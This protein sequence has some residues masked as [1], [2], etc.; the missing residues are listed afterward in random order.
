MQGF[1]SF[2]FLVFG[3]FCLVL[4]KAH[5]V[6]LFEIGTNATFLLTA[7]LELTCFSFSR[8][9]VLSDCFGF[10]CNQEIE[11]LEH[12]KSVLPIYLLLCCSYH[13]N[14]QQSLL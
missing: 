6:A 3:Q 8:E 12:C 10:Y 5:A 2:S 14:T 4:K 7:S 1:F 11:V 9:T 13:S